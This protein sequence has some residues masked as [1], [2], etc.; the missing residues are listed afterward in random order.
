MIKKPFDSNYSDR[1]IKPHKDTDINF[2]AVSPNAK[3][4]VSCSN[5]VYY[6]K[7]NLGQLKDS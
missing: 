4:V 3:L 6:I 1:N 2:L 5:F 7:L